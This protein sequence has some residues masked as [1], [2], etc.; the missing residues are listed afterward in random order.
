MDKEADLMPV[1]YGNKINNE[2]DPCIYLLFIQPLET[3]CSYPYIIAV[4]IL[5]WSNIQIRIWAKQKFWP[6]RV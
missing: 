5:V 2:L 1:Y 4:A 6:V 3:Y